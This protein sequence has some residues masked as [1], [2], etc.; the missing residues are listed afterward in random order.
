MNLIDT[1]KISHLYRQV[2]AEEFYNKTLNDKF[3]KDE[4]FSPEIRKK[5]LKIAND[6]YKSLNLNAPIKDIQLTG[7]L[8]NYN[9]N[10]Y[11]DLDVHIII[12]FLDINEDEKIVKMALDGQRYIWNQK[13]DIVLNIT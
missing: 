1:V 13:H 8:A 7:S 4:K 6:F 9:Y 12:D 5:L 2:L 3:W 10:V 11:S